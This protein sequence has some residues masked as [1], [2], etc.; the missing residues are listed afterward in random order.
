MNKKAF[1]FSIELLAAENG[2][3]YDFHRIPDLLIDIIENH[4]ERNGNIRTFDLTPNDEDLHT[5][6]DV[7]Y[8][9]TGY[10]TTCLPQ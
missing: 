2:T 1:F 9:D 4:G 10:R 7:F 8:Y 6:L 5:M 3:E